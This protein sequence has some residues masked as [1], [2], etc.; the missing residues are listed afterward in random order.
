MAAHTHIQCRINQN[1]LLKAN[2]VERL[3]LWRRLEY[4][5]EGTDFPV[6]WLGIVEMQQY[7]HKD[8][9]LYP[10]EKQHLQWYSYRIEMLNT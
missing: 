6:Y 5:I 7:L 10:G 9:N 2:N 4:W 3:A 1:T 8:Q